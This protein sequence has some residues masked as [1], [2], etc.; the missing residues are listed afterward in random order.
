MKRFQ[1]NNTDTQMGISIFDT[2]DVGLLPPQAIISTHSFATSRT[3]A[4]PKYMDKGFLFGKTQFIRP[5]DMPQSLEDLLNRNRNLV[6]VGHGFGS[7]LQVLRHLGLDL[8][9]SFVGMFDTADINNEVS[10]LPSTSNPVQLRQILERLGW[11]LA[12]LH[13]A[14]NDTNFTL[15]ALLLLAVDSYCGQ[16]ELLD[17]VAHDRQEILGAIGHAPLPAPTANPITKAKKLRQKLIR[18][19]EE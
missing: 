14:G 8:K 13:I 10:D 6:L 17:N 1:S 5:K 15:R 12:R 4:I 2:R 9:A 7:D 16:E 3:P 18:S 11:S 19:L